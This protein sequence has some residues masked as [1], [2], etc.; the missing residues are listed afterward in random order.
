[1]VA[2]AADSLL[3]AAPSEPVILGVDY[4]TG[5]DVSVEQ[6]GL[7]LECTAGCKHMVF[8]P[9][10]PTVDEVIEAV[11]EQTGLRVWKTKEGYLAWDRHDGPV[12][13]GITGGEPVRTIAEYSED[14]TDPLA[15]ALE[16]LGCAILGV[17]SEKAWALTKNEE[18]AAS[19][20]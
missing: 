7:V 11:T 19:H 17:D 15:T 16:E 6:G 2:F 13:I 14:I 3:P 1:M 9:L 20:Q 10:N 18:R 4:A 8:I 5:P 12:T